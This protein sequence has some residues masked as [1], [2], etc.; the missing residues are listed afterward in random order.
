MTRVAQSLYFGKN[1]EHKGYKHHTYRKPRTPNILGPRLKHR[2]RKKV[3]EA[4]L[5]DLEQDE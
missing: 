3:E 4:K 1:K 5:R 2:L